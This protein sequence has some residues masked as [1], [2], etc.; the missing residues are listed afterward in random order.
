MDISNL[1]TIVAKKNLLTKI[2]GQ[3]RHFQLHKIIVLS[4]EMNMQTSEIGN[5]ITTVTIKVI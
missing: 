1:E 2:N 4:I 5:K 3:S